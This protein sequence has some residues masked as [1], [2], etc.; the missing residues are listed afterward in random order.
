[1][2]S[3]PDLGTDETQ[4]SRLANHDCWAVLT[5][6]EL[7]TSRSGRDLLCRS[8][9][10]FVASGDGLPLRGK[11]ARTCAGISRTQQAMAGCVPLAE[12][13]VHVYERF[14]GLAT[15]DRFIAAPVTS[16]ALPLPAA[17]GHSLPSPP[18]ASSTRKN[19]AASKRRSES[20]QKPQ[21]TSGS[22]WIG[23][24]MADASA[25]TLAL[26]TDGHAQTRARMSTALTP[27]RSGAAEGV[28]DGRRP[29]PV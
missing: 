22:L 4:K 3:A 5:M 20:K 12:P 8:D 2:T 23:R 29:A 18:C 28:G 10:H 26:F 21:T 7:V 15:C 11:R 24:R 14:A 27:E 25:A 13:A 9:E 16:T 6:R 19:A 17:I 1:M